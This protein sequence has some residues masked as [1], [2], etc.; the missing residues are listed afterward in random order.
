MR[1]TATIPIAIPVRTLED[2]LAEPGEVLGA[3]GEEAEG[4]G[5]TV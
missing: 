1:T 3:V 5:A 2:R 4:D